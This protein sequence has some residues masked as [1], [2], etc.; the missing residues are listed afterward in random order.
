MK[1]LLFP[2][3]WRIF[4]DQGCVIASFT[5]CLLKGG[6]YRHHFVLMRYWPRKTPA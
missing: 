6:L 4:L 2:R 1:V 5:A 3:D